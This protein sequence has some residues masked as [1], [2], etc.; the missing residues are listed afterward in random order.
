MSAVGAAR[1]IARALP[2]RASSPHAPR[3][4]ARSLTTAAA[5]SLGEHRRQLA[6]R[7]GTLLRTLDRA[8]PD[9]LLDR[10]RGVEAALADADGAQ[11]WLALAVLT[12][13]LPLEEEVVE[14]LRRLRL[15]G[16]G[17]ALGPAVAA[18]VAP[19]RP[20]VRVEV[21]VGEVVV[22]VHHTSRTGLATGIQR[23][24]RET[25]R[26]WNR[27]HPVVL[28]GWTADG[29][30]LTRLSPADAARAVGD[31]PGAA[32]GSAGSDVL[33]PWAG[34]YA[35]LE[36]AT[37]E[38]RTRRIAALA[39][40]SG[41]GTGAVGFDCVPLTTAETTADAM[42]AAFAQM[43]AGLRHVD[44][45]ATISEAAAVE[46]RGW[47]GMLVGTGWAGPSVDAVVLPVDAVEPPE[48]ALAAARDR[49]LVADLPMLLCVGSH[50][51][52]K[53]HL[54]VLHAAELLWRRGVLFS[55][56]FVGGNA[57]HSERFTVRLGELKGAGRPVESV[58]ALDDASLWAAYRLARAV[59]FPS[60]NEGF[61]LPVAEALAS[62]TPVVTTRYGSTAEIAAGGGAVLVDPRNDAD[63]AAAMAAVLEDDALHARLSAEAAARPHRSWD[64]YA[65]ELWRVLVEAG[66]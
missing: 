27:D 19:T 46:Y 44:R 13:R 6:D 20:V 48:Q 37:E 12:G 26:R 47:R 3:P 53:N 7:M 16:P 2:A 57:W 5:S 36:L 58:P 60:L 22:D 8:V 1:R 54:A 41:N 10:A 52:R 40:W 66:R 25:A 49:L 35:L 64:A 50:E 61:G 65:S 21:V 51:P 15:D 56:L 63:L 38:P 11:V 18:A 62:G 4:H 39:R 29:T 34:S 24:A 32:S 23:V 55:L 31:P 59:L 43:L 28:A 17:A 45:V 30:A 33:V 14:T 9:G 42:G